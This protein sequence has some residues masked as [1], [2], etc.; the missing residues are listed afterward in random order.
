MQYMTQSCQ[1]VQLLQL[2]RSL[3]GQ[4]AEHSA[5]GAGAQLQDW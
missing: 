2:H 4:A 3:C 5:S 1:E